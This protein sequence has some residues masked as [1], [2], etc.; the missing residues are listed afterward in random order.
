MP[1]RLYVGTHCGLVV[2]QSDGRIWTDVGRAFNGRIVDSIAGSLLTPERVYCGVAHDGVYRTEDAG[3]HWTL[4]LA[5]DVRA[6]AIDP[7]DERVVYA[8]TE[9]I[10]LYR[11]RDGGLTWREVDGLLKLPLELQD[12]WWTPGGVS[13]IRHI[14]VDPRKSG[15][16]YLALEVGGVLRSLDAGETWEDVSRGLDSLDVHQVSGHPR[17]SSLFA[18]TARGFFAS[19]DPA[20]GWTRATAGIAHDFFHDF[21]TLSAGSVGPG[22]TL[23]LAT[24]S[25][26][27]GS[28]VREDGH[29]SA[30]AGIYRSNNGARS[31]E[32][33]REGLP[34]GLASMVSGFA[35][36]P[37]NADSVFAGLGEVSRA[38]ASGAAGSG[39]I[40]VSS[41]RGQSWQDLAITLPAVRVLLATTALSPHQ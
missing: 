10:R 14:F 24:A 1:V 37:T 17:N 25:D 28:W 30:L 3:A 26:P 9:P 8:G 23:L 18:S 21:V 33:A 34:E 20:R 4:A 2:L 35:R 7:S 40:V 39:G 27:P 15:V 6:L 29:F 16:L 41:D 13:H 12:T 5:G 22:P 38:N 32:Q 11:S 31:W 19:E 36:H